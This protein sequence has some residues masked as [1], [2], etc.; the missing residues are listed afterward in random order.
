MAGIIEKIFNIIEQRNVN[1]TEFTQQVGIARNTIY[2]LTDDSIKYS[3]LRK[4]AKVLNLPITYF[5]SDEEEQIHVNSRKKAKQKRDKLA[6]IERQKQLL[7]ELAIIT[8]E[9]EKE[10]KAKK[11]S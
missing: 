11:G 1:I 9:V 4:I 6:L 8:T 7:N 5:I 10:L 2:S 3:T